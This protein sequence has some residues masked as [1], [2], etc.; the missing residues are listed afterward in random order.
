M[1]RTYRDRDNYREHRH[2]SGFS[3]R[4]TRRQERNKVRDHIRHER[5]EDADTRQ[6]K[7]TEG[8]LSH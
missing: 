5:F 3:R 1:S 2:E 7:N 4:N 6:T 8:W